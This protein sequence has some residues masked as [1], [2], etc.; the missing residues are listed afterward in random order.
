MNSNYELVRFKSECT[1]DKRLWLNGEG[2]AASLTIE[3]GHRCE[4]YNCSNNHEIDCFRS[5]TH[6]ILVPWDL[7]K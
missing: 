7:V 1:R 3:R 4:L 2:V 5:D 6:E